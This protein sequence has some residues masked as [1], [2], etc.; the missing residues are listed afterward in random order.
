M[1]SILMILVALVLAAPALAKEPKAGIGLHDEPEMTPLGG[2][3]LR[4]DPASGDAKE[5]FRV[6]HENLAS[7][8][9][10]GDT[11]FVG[12]SDHMLH[13][14]SAADGAERWKVDAGHR[15]FTVC[16]GDKAVLVG[17][18]AD[19]LALDPAT[20]K[21]LWKYEGD[22]A[23]DAVLAVDT[24]ALLNSFD[25]PVALDLA[26]GKPRWRLDVQWGYFVFSKMAPGRVCIWKPDE[27]FVVE[28]ERGKTLW[29]STADITMTAPGAVPSPAVCDVQDVICQLRGDRKDSRQWSLHSL[30]GASG[31]EIWRADIGQGAGGAARTA[32]VG[33]A[34][35]CT[36]DDILRK[37]DLTTGKALWAHPVK[38]AN[39]TPAPVCAFGLVIVSDAGGDVTALDPSDGKSKWAAA[40]PKPAAGAKV[41]VSGI[42]VT[43]DAIFV[44]RNQAALR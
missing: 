27:I 34:A 23:V 6:A 32:V 20:G 26:S 33:L 37:F 24:V 25:G 8:A 36:L 41:Q 4:I 11:I 15:I 7:P 18:G 43:E 38:A 1:R 35:Y 9:V 10:L 40:A 28:T 30:E 5:L 17:A 29:Q 21:Q 19:L 12:G 39:Q 2:T 14:L 16:A 31:N 44:C 13:A 22:I 3:L 42:A